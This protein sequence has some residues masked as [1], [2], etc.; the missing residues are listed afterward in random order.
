VRQGIDTPTRYHT[1]HMVKKHVMMPGPD[2]LD[3]DLALPE[4]IHIAIHPVLNPEEVR[5]LKVL[6]DRQRTSE[7]VHGGLKSLLQ[8]NDADAAV[9]LHLLKRI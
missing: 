3:D 5:V 6:L 2:D 8:L 1:F 4:P 7:V 9:L